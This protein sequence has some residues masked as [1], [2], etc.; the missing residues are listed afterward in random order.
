MAQNLQYYKADSSAIAQC[1]LIY[2]FM[3]LQ[4]F[5]TIFA[6]IKVYCLTLKTQDYGQQDIRKTY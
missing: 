3:D 2:F 4:C 5:G 1:G 6:S